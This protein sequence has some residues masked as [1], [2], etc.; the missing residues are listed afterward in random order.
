MTLRRLGTLIGLLSTIFIATDASALWY[1]ASGQ[2]KMAGLSEQQARQQ[3]VEQAITNVQMFAGVRVTGARQLSNGLITADQLRMDTV[4]GIRQVEITQIQTKNGI[5]YVHIR[6]DIFAEEDQCQ[7]QGIFHPVTVT[8]FTINHPEQAQYGQIY[9]L[10]SDLTNTLQNQLRHVA[11]H[12]NVRTWLDKNVHFAPQREQVIGDDR[13]EIA[14]QLALHTDSQY[15]LFGKI[16]D[17][18]VTVDRGLRW[19]WKQRAMT[20]DIAY[21]VSL[22]DGVTGI[23]IWQKHYRDRAPWTFDSHQIIDSGSS[24]FWESSYGQ[25][26][27]KQLSRT[28][29]D[30][31][32]I[33]ACQPAYARV[34]NVD[35]KQVIINAGQRQGLQE[36][37]RVE[38]T[39]NAEF[40][41]S[42]GQLHKQMIASGRYLTVKQLGPN[43]AVLSAPAKV[44]AT[45]REDDLVNIT[46]Q[47]TTP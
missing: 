19:P 6:A 12:L 16:R 44:L 45:V 28:S 18:S 9:D 43:T 14:R 24:E 17:L 5:M 23:E 26:L 38:L 34:L 36:K 35:D 2:V 7:G 39:H 31:D 30:L 3:A 33:L 8:R 10:G 20:R 25:M 41:D 13:A 42:V 21:D 46:R 29:T 15:V 1:G 11:H 27:Q 40:T 47:Q 22:Y 32:R 37:Q 4:G